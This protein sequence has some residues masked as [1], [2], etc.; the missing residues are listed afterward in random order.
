M[1][2]SSRYTDVATRVKRQREELGQRADV[3]QRLRD[4][5]ASSARNPIHPPQRPRQR[6]VTTTLVGIAAG[7]GLLLCAA[8]ATLVIASGVW[9]QAQF[10][11][12]TTTVEGFYSALHQQNYTQAYS[13]F[14]TSAQRSLGEAQFQQTMSAAD[15]LAGAVES[16]T[17]TTSTVN[18]STATVTVEVVRRGDTTQAQVYQLTLTQEEQSWRITT[19]RQ[20]GTT[21][22]PTPAS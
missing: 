7:A 21:V 18:G 2:D 9:A 11:S 20:T 3:S 1:S 17:V 10:G 13:Y 4:L 19:I 6:P 8:L 22:A 15:M 12:P 14:S 5:S 16:D